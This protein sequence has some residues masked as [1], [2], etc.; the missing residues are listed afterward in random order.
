[1]NTINY[2]GLNVALHM[3]NP[4]KIILRSSI[5]TIVF[6]CV[7]RKDVDNLYK[8]QAFWPKGL[9]HNQVS[10]ADNLTYAT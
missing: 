3:I 8:Q 4:L 10:L 7:V 5:P 9:H 1:M 6:Y 2:K